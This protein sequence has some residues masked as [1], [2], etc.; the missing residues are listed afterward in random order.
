MNSRREN[1]CVCLYM[2]TRRVSFSQTRRQNFCRPLQ[3]VRVWLWTDTWLAHIRFNFDTHTED[4]KL[5]IVA[6]ALWKAGED[7]SVES[8]KVSCLFAM[9]RNPNAEVDLFEPSVLTQEKFTSSIAMLFFLLWRLEKKVEKNGLVKVTMD[10]S[11]NRPIFFFN[12]I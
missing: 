12:S 8:I 6:E 4:T 10:S 2:R 7:Y 3:V 11:F 5:A 9:I 1:T